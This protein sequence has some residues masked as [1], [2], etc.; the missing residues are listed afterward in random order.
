MKKCRTMRSNLVSRRKLWASLLPSQWKSLWRFTLSMRTT[1]SL[2]RRLPQLRRQWWGPRFSRL[3]MPPALWVFCTSDD[4]IDLEQWAVDAQC[5]RGTPDLRLEE[6]EISPKF[7]TFH[8]YIWGPQWEHKFIQPS[9]QVLICQLR[10]YLAGCK[11][12]TSFNRRHWLR[13]FP[14]STITERREQLEL[15]AASGGFPEL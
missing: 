11:L 3:G 4:L 1:Q 14:A 8:R 9:G 6:P 5:L 2:R 13:L 12:L 7:K 15:L 10:A